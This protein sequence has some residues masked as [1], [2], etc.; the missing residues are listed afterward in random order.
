MGMEEPRALD[1]SER[2]RIPF[3]AR[4]KLR[5]KQ[6]SHDT[7]VL[8]FSELREPARGVGGQWS[9]ASIREGET[10]LCMCSRTSKRP[11]FVP[12]T[13]GRHLLKLGVARTSGGT[14]FE[15][16]VELPKGGILVAICEPIQANVVYR[17]SPA[18]DTW[19]TG[20]VS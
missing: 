17:R 6:R 11:K 19:W 8:L 3:R 4:R 7:G 14:S 9:V 12:L 13:P 16:A 1:L 15:L 5:A 20:I 18:F 2:G 10:L